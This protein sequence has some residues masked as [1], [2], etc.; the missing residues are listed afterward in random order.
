MEVQQTSQ[1][2]VS[3]VA[4]N[5]LVIKLRKEEIDD[6]RVDQPLGNHP[7]GVD[8]RFVRVIKTGGFDETEV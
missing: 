4:D 6:L 5:P 2:N 3:F 8:V 7:E 1:T